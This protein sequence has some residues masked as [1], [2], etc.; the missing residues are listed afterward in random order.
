MLVIT[1]CNIRIWR[2]SSQDGRALCRA[3]LPRV[4]GR[5]VATPCSL[6]LLCLGQQL[7][8]GAAR[9]APAQPAPFSVF[10]FRTRLRQKVRVEPFFPDGRHVG[11]EMSGGGS[12]LKFRHQERCLPTGAGLCSGV[13]FPAC[14]EGGR[15]KHRS[16]QMAKEQTKS[17][18]LQKEL[19]MT[20]FVSPCSC[21][22]CSP[23]RSSRRRP[24][25]RRRGS[26]LPIR[27]SRTATGSSPP[28]IRART[29]K[30]DFR[31][32][33]AAETLKRYPWTDKPVAIMPAPAFHLQWHL[34]HQAQR[35]HPRQS[36]PGR[37]DEWR[38]S[39]SGRSAC[40]WA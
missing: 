25:R 11:T 4:G 19:P 21:W 34:G 31:V 5:P 22:A 17:R 16:R 14:P 32:R 7:P 40:C 33:V 8:P 37:L 9:P 15:D 6:C 27:S 38:S 1:Y 36:R 26:I 13:P 28:G 35:H 18:L 20:R 29:A 23:K 2:N 12:W 39:A 30:C 3:Q 10:G 24:T